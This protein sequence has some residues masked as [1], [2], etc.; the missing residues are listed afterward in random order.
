MTVNVPN[1]PGDPEEKGMIRITGYMIKIMGD[2]ET[3]GISLKCV[4]SI[5]THIDRT[6]C[7]NSMQLPATTTIEHKY[8][9]HLCIYAL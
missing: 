5:I 1:R 8:S 4:L 7:N 2:P 3:C 9:K 6:T